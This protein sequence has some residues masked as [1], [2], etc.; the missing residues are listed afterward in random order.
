MS[1]APMTEKTVPST[2][3]E[4]SAWCGSLITIDR[5]R[6]VKIGPNPAHPY[7]KGAFCV[8]GMR[9]AIDSVYHPRRVLHP[10]RRRGERGAGQW[11]QISW[12]E[13]LDD[14]TNRLAD[15]R[16]QYGPQAII[17]AVSSAYFSRGVAVALLLRSLGSP[18]WMIN[19]D[20]CGGCRAVS[21]LV[22]GLNIG[23]GED[24][25][26]TRC[27]L[28]VGRNPAAA[29]AIQWMALRRAKVRGAKIVAVDPKRTPVTRIADLWLRPRP[30]TDAA[31]ALGMMHVILADGTHDVQFVEQ[32][33]HGFEALKVRVADFPPDVAAALTGVAAEEIV[34]A[35]RL[36]ADGPS[37]FVSGHGIDA[38]S[39][40]VQTF[41]AFHC[42]AAI[43]GF[44]DRS[45][46]NRRVKFPMGFRT[47]L[48]VLKDAAFRLPADIERQT[49]GAE[50]FPLWAGPNGWQM[51]CHNP[52]AIRA[53]LTGEPYPIRAAYIS[54]VNIAVTYPDTQETVRALRSLDCVVVA[55]SVMTPTAELADIVLPKTVTLEEEEV[56]L[57]PGGP[58]VLYTAP[59]LP[60]AGE[61]KCDLEIA[62]A[63]LDRLEAR[64]ALFRNLIPWRNQH[65]FNT[66][67][68][69]NSGIDIDKLRDKGFAE[70]SYEMGDFARHPFPTP[71]GKAELY[72]TLLDA[73]GQ[74]PLPNHVPE[75]VVP[76]GEA[77]YP[78][79]LLT[80]DREK[81]YHH[82]RFRDHAWA[83]KVSPE[84]RVLVHP[85]DAARFGIGDGQWVAIETAARLGRC[86]LRAKVTMD[87]PEGVVSTG[88]GWWLPE[89]T[90]PDRGIFDVN[91]NAAI[92]YAAPWD[93]ISG[94]A[95]TRRL[96]CRLI[97]L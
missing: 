31:L 56:S 13:A 22:T 57:A 88:M 16:V 49:I 21:D 2:C 51:A 40:G 41:R 14:I 6:V 76:A 36:Y 90:T 42:L 30:G 93:P 72:S 83:R 89:C 52:S 23:M 86:R 33:C 19:Q 15:I 97:P 3:W 47:Y 27:A 48:S 20:L 59:V 87:T 25:E 85:D 34:A 70:F 17:G 55:T 74:D 24:I 12:N 62:I 35:T 8:K 95:D 26:H 28:V 53:M 69:G 63:L 79:L 65:E 68:L 46:G 60:P 66:F 78:L 50:H 73:L 81:T 29:D 5:E 37:C 61:A 39:R 91:I 11:E 45:G 9:G 80:G 54:G 94:S 38:S 84:P 77:G 7:S 92:S 82:S 1:L 67:L 43:C 58:C 96:P 71:T 64:G 32:W 18:N 10:L 75:R 44:I 4:C